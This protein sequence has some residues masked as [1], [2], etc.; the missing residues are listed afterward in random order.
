ML[1]TL[2]APASPLADLNYNQSLTRMIEGAAIGS[3]CPGYQYQEGLPENWRWSCCHRSERYW[4]RWSWGEASV[5]QTNSSTPKRDAHSWQVHKF[6]TEPNTRARPKISDA[7]SPR[8]TVAWGR[9]HVGHVGCGAC[10]YKV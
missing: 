5:E 4:H 2:R 1:Y 9:V 8:F 7:W 6:Q 3:L 10:V